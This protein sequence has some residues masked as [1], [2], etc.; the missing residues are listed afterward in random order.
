MFYRGEVPDDGRIDVDEASIRTAE[1]WLEAPP[2]DTPWVLF[3]PLIAPHCPFQ[4]TEEWRSL[5]DADE[6]PD[7]IPAG[8]RAGEPRY[9]QEMR[10]RYGLA[11]IT[12]QMWRE[13]TATYYAMIS[14][15]DSHLGRVLAAVEQA[16]AAH[17]TATMFFA[18]HGEYLGDF[19]LIEKWPSAM[20][21]CITRDPLIM[22][23]PGIP[24]EVREQMVEM[25]DVLPT[26]L[27]LAGATAPH[28]HFGRS[29][30][31]V[32]DD[33]TIVHRT[34][35][36][37]EGGFTAEE[38]SQLERADFPYDLK[39]ELQHEHPGMVGKVIAVRDAEY[40]YIWRLY[41]PIELYDRVND[42]DE[43]VNI[44]GPEYAAVEERMHDAMLRWLVETADV[45]P[46]EVD[47][48][49]AA[50][51]LSV[52]GSDRMTEPAPTSTA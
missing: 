50:V 46:F 33:P 13:V 38:E 19:G 9:M 48:R 23:G 5:Y 3:V 49:L 31:P 1:H 39:A 12:P 37:T 14:R 10:E 41:E 32:L 47:P 29:L 40:T 25:I 43:R 52:P 21:D 26:I 30:L 28:R 22:A 18:D 35:T 15:M 11:R 7:P 42:P 34:Y 6:L 27:D 20:H 51:D 44:A 17:D 16:G 4:S 8:E 36:F 24:A 45:I 2:E